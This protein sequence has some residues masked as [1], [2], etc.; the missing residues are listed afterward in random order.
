MPKVIRSLRDKAARARRL[1]GEVADATVANRMLDYATELEVQAETRET[2]LDGS[3]AN[4]SS[5]TSSGC[6]LPPVLKTPS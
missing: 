2:N 5:V 4:S 6:G 3:R 1:A